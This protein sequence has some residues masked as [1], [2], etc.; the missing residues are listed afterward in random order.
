MT[1]V[2]RI[3][4]LNPT[5][6]VL[7][8]SAPDDYNP[9]AEGDY[10]AGDNVYWPLTGH[11]TAVVQDGVNYKATLLIEPEDLPATFFDEET[12]RVGLEDGEYGIAEIRTRRLSGRVSGYDLRLGP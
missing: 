8:T 10:A 11:F 12:T 9:Q 4:R 2:Q 7:I 6:A 1:P 3:I 5:S